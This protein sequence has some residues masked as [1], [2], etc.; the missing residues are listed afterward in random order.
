VG[1]RVYPRTFVSVSYYYN[2]LTQRVGLVQS[3]HHHQLIKN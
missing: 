1:R 2:N 3:G